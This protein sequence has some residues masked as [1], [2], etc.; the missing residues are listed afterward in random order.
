MIDS[1]WWVLLTIAGPA[2]LGAAIAYAMISQSK[3]SPKER[4][5]LNDAIENLYE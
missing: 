2:L 1:S 4:R 3:L 5:E